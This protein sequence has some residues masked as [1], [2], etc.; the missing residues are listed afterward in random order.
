MLKN[1]LLTAV[2]SLNRHKFFSAINIFGLAVAMSIC[3]VL[4]MLV[5]D[6]MNYDRYNTD[7]DR[8]YRVTTLNVDEKGNVMW[9]NQVN[10]ATCDPLAPTLLDGYT[11]IDDAVRLRRGFGNNWLKLEGQDVNL[12]LAGFFADANV[13]EFFQYELEYGNA[14]TALKDPFTVVLT[15]QAADKLFE[16]EN[17]VGQTLKVG[18]LGL[19]TVTGILK[20]TDNKSH[21]VFEGL[22]S[23]ASVK[24]LEDA[25]KLSDLSEMWLAYF[26]TWTYVR[27]EQGKSKEDVQAQLDKVY[28]KHIAP[29]K[30]IYKMRFFLEPLLGITPGDIVQNSIGPQMP[31]EIV[32]FLGGLALVILLTSCFN[33]TNLSIARSLTR[34]RE[35]GVRKVA[36]AA[37][38]Q[39]FTQFISESVVVS[40][41]ALAMAILLLVILKPM[42]LQLEFA[43]M[44]RWDLYSGVAV[45]AI[46]IVFASF[47]GILA[48]FFPAVVLSGFQ[49]VAVLKSLNNVKLFSRM[50]M[51]KA[52]LVSQFALSLFFIVTVIVIHKQMN[53]FLTKEHGFNMDTNVM[54]KLHNTSYATLK[55][56]LEKYNNITTVTAVSHVPAAGTSYGAAIKRNAEDPSSVDAGFFYVDEDYAGNMELKLLAGKFFTEEQAASNKN[57]VVINEAAVERLKFEGPHDAIGE[58]IH[59]CNDSTTKIIAGVVKNYNHRDLIHHINPV[60]LMYNEEEFNVMQVAYMGTYENA[61]RSI[62]KAWATVNPGL[63]ADYVEVKSEI[64]KAYELIFGDLVQVI[65]FISFLAIMISCLGLLG[66]ATYA[67]ET[68]VKEISIRK[69]LGSSE[70][71]LVLLLSK[72]FLRM[73]AI[74]VMIGMPL[75]WLAN[76]YWLEQ[77]AYH[78]TIGAGTIIISIV[79]LIF[80]GVI[81]V[82]SQTLRATL[83]RPVDNL[84]DE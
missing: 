57:F 79:I 13:L 8:I 72:G 55:T 3:M 83:V 53:M 18:D 44:F 32:Y 64:N 12:P 19:F 58:S 7:G 23:M 29:S 22:A 77:L 27:A 54:V 71:A 1:Y 5:A 4:I 31:W 28:F 74:S 16:D 6:Q 48:G 69:I 51:R 2:R 52:L 59:F 47:V 17:P 20:E 39:I 63:K 42:I 70:M 61:A 24:S 73:L 45:Y 36:G 81:T 67:T 78:T 49:P 80:F 50:G 82:G 14:K 76:N 62:E 21:I 9:G 46:F 75:A 68:R 26:N 38:S 84:K 43:Q 41:V 11:G 30:E 25:G 10:A 65:G 34:A 56:E 66:M 15:R 35:I 60:L 40:M 37:R 33:F